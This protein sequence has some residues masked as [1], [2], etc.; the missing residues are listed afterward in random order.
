MGTTCYDAWDAKILGLSLLLVRGIPIAGGSSSITLCQNGGNRGSS[1]SLQGGSEN[2]QSH[3]SGSS[4]IIM[5]RDFSS[6]VCSFFSFFT[7]FLFLKI[8]GSVHNLNENFA[9]ATNRERRISALCYF[10]FNLECIVVS[11][12]KQVGGMGC[13]VGVNFSLIMKLKFEWVFFHHQ[14]NNSDYAIF[15]SLWLFIGRV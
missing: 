1:I 4:D 5:T 15:F 9:F 11:F 10:L 12:T 6:F 13:H 8:V 3:K 7:V 14:Y 2:Q